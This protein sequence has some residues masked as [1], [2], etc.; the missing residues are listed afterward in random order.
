MDGLLDGFGWSKSD[1][2][3]GRDGY[4]LPGSRVAPLAGFFLD[5][6][7]GAQ[8]LQPQVSVNGQRIRDGVNHRRQ[9]LFRLTS[10]H[11]SIAR[12]E[13]QKLYLVQNVPPDDV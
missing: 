12:H 11:I 5:N 9:S 13:I 3:T 2:T 7:K 1:N 8:S 10:W 6:G 4:F